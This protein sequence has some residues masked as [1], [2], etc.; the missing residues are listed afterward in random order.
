MITQAENELMTLVEGDAPMGRLM[1]EHYWIPFA[2]SAHLVA[3]AGPVPVRLLG[4]NYVAFRAEDGRVGFLDELCPH[5][6]ASLVLARAEGNCLR[7]IYHGWKIDAAGCVVEAPTQQVRAERFA[8]GVPVVHFP[9]REAGGLA[10]VWLGGA[11]APAFP[12]LPFADEDLYRYWVTSRVPSN[13]LQGLEGSVDSVHVAMLHQTWIALSVNMEEHANLSYALA[14]AAPTYE[15]QATS[16]GLR[17]AALRKTADGRSYVRVTEHMMPLVT[18]TPVGSTEPRAGAVFVI[19]P[20]DDTHHLLFF[21]TIGPTPHSA[22][23]LDQIK[24]QDPDYAPDPAD[25]A[26]LRGDR[27]NAWGQDRALMRE[28]HFTGFGR[29]LLEEDV[30]IQT[31]MGPILDRTKEHLS[32]SDVAVAQLRR[33]LL[34]ALAAAHTGALPP[35]SARA[36]ERVRLPNAAEM[37]VDEGDRWEDA[38]LGQLTR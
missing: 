32:S 4:E 28:G 30:A 22:V 18:I 16:Y 29:S 13:W 37:L 25:Y 24:M 9:V 20:V 36:P 1:R 10:W 33:M 23:P 14:Q 6:R 21:G 15:T 19:S 3:G 38:A 8:A 5:R 34:D 17:A 31:S 11:D 26:G 7:C 12:D 27:W 2:Q 35:G